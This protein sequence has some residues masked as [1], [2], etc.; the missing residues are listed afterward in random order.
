MLE[1]DAR[2]RGIELGPR[3]LKQGSREPQ[4]GGL[5]QDD[6]YP[7]QPHVI[8]SL[9]FDNHITTYLL[10]LRINFGESNEGQ[11]RFVARTITRTEGNSF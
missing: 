1:L 2:C 10:H 3:S 5:T 4:G 6:L 8:D 7:L 9:G 11:Y